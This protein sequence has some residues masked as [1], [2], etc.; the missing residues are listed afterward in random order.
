M[1]VCF[2]EG[3]PQMKIHSENVSFMLLG[4]CPR[5]KSTTQS[6]ACFRIWITQA[7]PQFIKLY[8]MPQVAQQKFPIS[9][10]WDV[11]ICWGQ[12]TVRHKRMSVT[13]LG[14]RRTSRWLCHS[15]GELFRDTPW[16]PGREPCCWRGY[17][18]W[19]CC[20]CWTHWPVWEAKQHYNY[21]H[22]FQRKK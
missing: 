21:S 15:P 20:C 5:L 2:L 22:T 11:G 13:C 17:L 3:N 12:K 14:W 19:S 9:K 18:R 4:Y 10:L 16:W 7:S 8:K 6:T 1:C